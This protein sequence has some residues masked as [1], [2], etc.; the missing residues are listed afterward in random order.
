MNTEAVKILKDVIIS[1]RENKNYIHQT[2]DFIVGRSKVYSEEF[3]FRFFL[4]LENFSYNG[5][6]IK[7]H[8]SSKIFHT[9]TF[10]SISSDY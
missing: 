9:T 3:V 8:L 4:T 5:E 10:N 7:L 6:K 2:K 1:W